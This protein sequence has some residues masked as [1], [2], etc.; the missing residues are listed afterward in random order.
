MVCTRTVCTRTIK[1]IHDGVKNRVRKVEGD[2]EH[3]LDMMGLHQRST[4]NLLLICLD[5]G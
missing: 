2:S 3:F 4:L 5:N 1:D